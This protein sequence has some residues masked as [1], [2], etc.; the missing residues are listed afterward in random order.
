MTPTTG[1]SPLTWPA[2]LKP[3]RAACDWPGGW[4]EEALAVALID[5]ARSESNIKESRTHER[6]LDIVFDLSPTGLG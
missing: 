4:S 5:G 6:T 2:Y 1:V 3:G